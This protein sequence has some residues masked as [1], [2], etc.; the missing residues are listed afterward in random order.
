MNIHARLEILKKEGPP[1]IK[2]EAAIVVSGDASFL[3]EFHTKRD[4]VRVLPFEVREDEDNY[5]INYA[6]AF[7]DEA[8]GNKAFRILGEVIIPKKKTI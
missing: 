5:Y 8:F 2:N 7:G 4:L 6:D 3:R 1:N